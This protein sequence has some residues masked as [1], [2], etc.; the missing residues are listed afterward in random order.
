ALVTG[1]AGGIGLAS[2]RL[3]AEAGARVWI[4]DLDPETGRGAASSIGAQFVPLDVSSS[5]SVDAAVDAIVA[6]EGRLDIGVNC[7]GIRHLGGGAE[8]LTD[9]EWATVLDI[10]TSG[11]F[12]SCRAEAKAMLAGGGGAI[13]NI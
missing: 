5:E 3:L 10:N 11:V 1:G 12:R 4:G 8:G 13:V 7:A 6:A 2:A 9:E